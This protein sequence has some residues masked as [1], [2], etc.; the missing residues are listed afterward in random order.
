MVN[1]PRPRALAP[2][3]NKALVRNISSVCSVVAI[4]YIQHASAKLLESPAL[5]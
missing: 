5:I 2:G 4:N 1:G 3:P